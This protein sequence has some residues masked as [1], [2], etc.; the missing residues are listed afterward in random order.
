MAN[1]ASQYRGSQNNFGF[2]KL[3]SCNKQYKAVTQ[4]QIFNYS[5][6]TTPS[7]N[8]LRDP[9]VSQSFSKDFCT[10]LYSTQG[11][12]CLSVPLLPC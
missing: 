5:C 12:F 10:L 8:C 9:A 6:S 7:S 4:A 11:L 1:D 3:N 2:S